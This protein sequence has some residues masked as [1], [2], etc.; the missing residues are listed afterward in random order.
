MQQKQHNIPKYCKQGSLYWLPCLLVA[1]LLAI[2][3]C[4]SIDCP[5]QNRVY[6][7]YSLKK[8]NGTA[9]T[10]KVDTL[11]ICSRRADGRDTILQNRITGVTTFDLDISYINPVDTLHMT[12]LDTMGNTY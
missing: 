9:D 5:V 3:G 2:A 6:T 7:V 1:T 8:A 4:S 12:L 11:S 10:L